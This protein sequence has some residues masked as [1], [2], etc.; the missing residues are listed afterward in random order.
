MGIW[1]RELG[2]DGW[3]GKGVMEGFGC[4]FMISC[5]FRRPGD[6]ITRLD[7]CMLYPEHTCN[8]LMGKKYHI[9]H[10]HLDD[11]VLR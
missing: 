4:F 3:G 8:V 6:S 2:M 9:V 1:N 7:G 11:S 10:P 5:I